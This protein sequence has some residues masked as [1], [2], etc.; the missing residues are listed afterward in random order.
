MN[1][2]SPVNLATGAEQ[3]SQRQ[4]GL[5]GT[6]I[7]FQHVEEQIHRFILLVAQQEVHPGHVVTRQAVSVVLFGLLCTSAPHIPSVSSGNG[8]KQK[9]QLQHK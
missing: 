6:G 2:D 8:Q 4:V 1:T 9:Q 3:V 7:L 5:N